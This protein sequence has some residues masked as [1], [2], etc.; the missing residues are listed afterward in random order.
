MQPKTPGR[1]M[2]ANNNLETRIL[3]N[4]ITQ[5]HT[6]R[7]GK[8]SRIPNRN[9]ATV[10]GGL[11]Q[12]GCNSRSTGGRQR[13]K[14]SVNHNHEHRIITPRHFQSDLFHPNERKRGRSTV[15][16]TLTPITS[17]SQNNGQRARKAPA[18]NRSYRSRSG[19]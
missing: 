8:T 11:G 7:I 16:F 4:W 1:P 19:R 17:F 12:P 13:R 6:M 9:C 2:T 3:D 10:S 18:K 5:R 14:K 15:R